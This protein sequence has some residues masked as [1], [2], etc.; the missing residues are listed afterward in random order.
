MAN[1]R[2]R[3]WNLP[4]SVLWQ[5][6]FLQMSHIR[7]VTYFSLN[8]SVHQPV[9]TITSNTKEALKYIQGIVHQFWFEG[10]PRC[11]KP[12]RPTAA[13]ISCFSAFGL[14][15]F[16]CNLSIVQ[17]TFELCHLLNVDVEPFTVHVI[18]DIERLAVVFSLILT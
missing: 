4:S 9:I 7:A 17:L 2:Q 13:L 6:I 8:Q 16:D 5:N 11:A 3:L 1:L 15:F 18:E 12:V 10:M 14:I